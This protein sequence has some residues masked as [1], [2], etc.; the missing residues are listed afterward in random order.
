MVHFEKTLSSENLFEGRIFRVT[1]SK[2][3]LEDGKTSHREIVC[4]PG[5]AAILPMTG[6]GEVYLVRQFRYAFGR[7]LLEIPA[8]KLEP[9]EDPEAAA[10]RELWEECGFS[11]DSVINLMPVYPTVGYDTEVIHMYLA[12][13]LRC[14]E[15]HPDP[16][17]F[18]TAEKLPLKD[19]V[20]MV[21]RGEIRDGK[22]VAALLKVQLLL[23]RG[24][25]Q[26]I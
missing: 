22:T 4:H 15:A 12:Q 8:G 3:L 19:A 13:G 26:L 25:L 9:G 11:A 23:D 5:G 10:R 16:G 6:Q 1:R 24:E 20:D 2:V 14:G 7:E 17:E 21:L 18:V